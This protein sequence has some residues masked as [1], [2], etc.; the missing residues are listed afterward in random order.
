MTQ[1]DGRPDPPGKPEFGKGIFQR[2]N[3]RL[4]VC[5]LIKQTV[6][7]KYVRQWV[8]QIRAQEFVTSVNRISENRLSLVKLL[9]HARILGPLTGEQKNHLSGLKIEYGRLNISQVVSYFFF[10]FA[11]DRDTMCEMSPSDI[12]GV[13]YIRYVGRVFPRQICRISRRKL[14]QCVL[15]LCRQGQDMTRAGDR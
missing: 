1:H 8:S 11:C 10:G 5:G 6:S 4:G 3:R 12:R 14:F 9:S 13:T 15:I 2:K 7:C